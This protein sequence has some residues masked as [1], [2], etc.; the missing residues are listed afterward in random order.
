MKKVDELTKN[1][2][3]M[4]REN[5]SGHMPED[6][7]MPAI[8]GLKLYQIISAVNGQIATWSNL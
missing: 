8:L 2:R 7:E 3:E 1:R 6:C 4:D 5:S